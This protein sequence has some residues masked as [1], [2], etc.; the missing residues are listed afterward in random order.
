[1]GTAIAFMNVDVYT[2]GQSNGFEQLLIIASDVGRVSE[3][4]T[5]AI[6]GLGLLT[7]GMRSVVSRVSVF[8]PRF[9]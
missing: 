6:V 1:M 7:M 5:L 2:A 4:G 8:P 3:P 9:R